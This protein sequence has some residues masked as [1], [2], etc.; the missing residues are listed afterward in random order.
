MTTTA[1]TTAQMIHLSES[2]RGFS[3]WIKNSMDRVYVNAIEDW[4]GLSVN[5]YNTGNVCAAA[6]DG[7]R[8]SN[9]EARRVLGR[10][11]E[12]KIYYDLV[13]GAWAYRGDADIARTVINRIDAWIADGCPAQKQA[14]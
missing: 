12:T 13:A 5:Y 14:A 7:S 3:R 11:S 6:L 8:I 4:Y 10:I 9:S 1:S 2:N